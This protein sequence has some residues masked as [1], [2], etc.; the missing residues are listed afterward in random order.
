MKKYMRIFFN[1]IIAIMLF[2]S[3]GCK[4]DNEEVGE[5][6]LKANAAIMSKAML[7]Y[8]HINLEGVNLEWSNARITSMALI[9][10][11]DGGDKYQIAGMMAVRDTVGFHY[12]NE[13]TI[14]GVYYEHSNKFVLLNDFIYIDSIWEK[15]TDNPLW[16]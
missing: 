13:F 9:G 6:R 12:H 1:V 3:V 7:E 2:F 10:A 11:H 16:K 14:V 15:T 4:N 5:Y 8:Y